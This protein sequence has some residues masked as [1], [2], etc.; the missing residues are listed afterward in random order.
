[1][2]PTVQRTYSSRSRKPQ[3]NSSPI[4]TLSSSPASAPRGLKRP[5]EQSSSYSSLDNISSSPTPK[6]PKLEKIRPKASKTNASSKPKQKTL[7]QLHF[8]IDRSVVRTCPTCGFTYTKGAV[9]DETLHR[10]HCL[11][12]QRGMQWGKEE[13][14]EA[15]KAGVVEIA[16]SISLKSGT[17][18]RIISCKLGV[19]GKIGSKVCF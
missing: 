5:L 7:T 18:G 2:P 3:L 14:R 6:R 4:S 17:R 10:S 11:R 16:T 19:G 12:V 9:E 13:I 15:E 1:M 8:C